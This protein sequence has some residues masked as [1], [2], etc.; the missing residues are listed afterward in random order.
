MEPGE[1]LYTSDEHQKDSLTRRHLKRPS[2]ISNAAQLPEKDNTKSSFGVASEDFQETKGTARQSSSLLFLHSG[3]SPD[4]EKEHSSKMVFG[5]HAGRTDRKAKTSTQEQNN[6]LGRW[7]SG[8][9]QDEVRKSASG[10]DVEANEKSYRLNGFQKPL[11]DG[12]EKKERSPRKKEAWF[13]DNR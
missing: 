5:P 9:G 6:L 4:V 3:A 13:S 7:M 12:S 10:R 8:R 1:N 11:G 2:G